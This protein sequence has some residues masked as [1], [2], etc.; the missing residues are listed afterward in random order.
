MN[1][2]A[3]MRGHK[4]GFQTQFDRCSH[5]EVVKQYGQAVVYNKIN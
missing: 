2:E 5:P 4:E 3:M 1:V